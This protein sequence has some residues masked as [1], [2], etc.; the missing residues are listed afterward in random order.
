VGN[1]IPSAPVTDDDDDDDDDDN[2][3]SGIAGV[4]AFVRSLVSLR[5]C[6]GREMAL[7]FSSSQR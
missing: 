7:R 2:S 3:R 4:N 5:Q 1:A 6:V